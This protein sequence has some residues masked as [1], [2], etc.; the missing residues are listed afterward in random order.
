MVEEQINLLK[1]INPLD[2]W[3]HQSYDDDDKELN[4]KIFNLKSANISNIVDNM[5]FEKIFGH[6]FVTLANKVINTSKKENQII[7]NDIKKNMDIL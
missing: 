5:L 6:K 2:D 1:K 3:W 4:L 7:I